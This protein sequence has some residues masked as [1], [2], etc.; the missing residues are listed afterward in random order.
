[1]SFLSVRQLTLQEVKQGFVQRDED[2]TDFGSCSTLYCDGRFLAV[3]TGTGKLVLQHSAS[4][5]VGTFFDIANVG[6][7]I[8]GS[9]NRFAV[10]TEFLRF[11]RVAL[12]GT[13]TAGT[14]M[15]QLDIIGRD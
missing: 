4:G 2:I 12:V 14:P 13:V 15:A 5:E 1:M 3:G 8:D 10:V 11:V 7:N 9:S 6:W